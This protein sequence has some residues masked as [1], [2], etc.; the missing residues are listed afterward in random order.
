[1]STCQ[2]CGEPAESLHQVA[3]QF[4]IDTIKKNN[5]QWVETDGSCAKCVEYYRN[6][7]E[8]VEVT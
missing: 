3:E 8:G 6:F 1:M 5:P 7:D 4:V 2:L